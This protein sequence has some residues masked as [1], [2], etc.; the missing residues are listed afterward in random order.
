MVAEEVVQ[1]EETAVAVVVEMAEVAAAVEVAE[2][3]T[4]TTDHP[5][6][7]IPT[8]KGTLPI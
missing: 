1:A 8:S 5:G 3:T 2:V 4:A 7:P 6:P